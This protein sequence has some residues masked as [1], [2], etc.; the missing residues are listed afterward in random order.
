METFL[1]ALSLFQWLLLSI[2]FK[3]LFSLWKNF[4]SFWKTKSLP[5]MTLLWYGKKNL[6]ASRFSRDTEFEP[7]TGSDSLKKVELFQLVTSQTGTQ[8]G[9]QD[10][11]HMVQEPTQIS[12]SR[13]AAPDKER[14]PWGCSRKTWNVLPFT[15]N[16]FSL[17][18]QEHCCHKSH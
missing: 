9:L 15:R 10:L 18:A 13:P 11:F 12:W 6:A 8:W 7:G 4:H 16:L 17:Q 2:F 1:T 3:F 5:K 14:F